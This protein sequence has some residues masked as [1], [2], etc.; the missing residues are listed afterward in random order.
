M[1]TQIAQSAAQ[2]LSQ[3]GCPSGFLPLA[4]AQAAVETGGFASHVQQSDNNLSGIMYLGKPTVQL[5][6]TQGSAYPASESGTAH[7][8][9]F[10]S[11]YDWAVDYLRILNLDRNGNGVR[12]I[13]TTTTDQLAAELKAQGYY[14]ATQS[15]YAAA[16]AS[17]MPQ[18]NNILAT[19]GV[20]DYKKKAH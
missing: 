9:R 14:T 5:N 13:D 7:Y 20:T 3:A 4:L 2:A 10:A 1:N 12:P 17:W 16:L 18:V 6:A 8:A 19:L 15:S 11:V